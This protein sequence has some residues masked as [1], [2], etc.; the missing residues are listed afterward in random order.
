MPRIQVIALFP[1]ETIPEYVRQLLVGRI[2]ETYSS[3]VSVP[4]LKVVDSVGNQIP[5]DGWRGYVIDKEHFLSVLDEECPDAAHWYR[6]VSILKE[7][8]V[9]V[10]LLETRYCRIVR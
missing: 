6:T 7:P 2:F 3:F 9:K 10:Y 1:S 8:N 4:A 5:D